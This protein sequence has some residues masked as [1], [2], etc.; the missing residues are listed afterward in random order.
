MKR[1]S[2]ILEIISCQTCRSFI[3]WNFALVLCLCYLNRIVDADLILHRMIHIC[4][5]DV[6]L[7]TLGTLMTPAASIITD[8]SRSIQTAIILLGKYAYFG[9]EFCINIV[10]NTLWAFQERHVLMICVSMVL[11]K[12]GMDTH[13]A[14]FK[15]LQ[16]RQNCFDQFLS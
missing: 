2:F 4:H 12:R 8:A 15:I 14:N 6:I 10:L 9:L 1:Y 3:I 7:F 11:C 16:K 5:N 13:A